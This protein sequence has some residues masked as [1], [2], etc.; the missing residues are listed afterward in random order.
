MV[1]IL[2]YG[3]FILEKIN[4]SELFPVHLHSIVLELITLKKLKKILKKKIEIYAIADHSSIIKLKINT[5][6]TGNFL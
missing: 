3:H 5:V 1:N 6:N 2:K 4:V